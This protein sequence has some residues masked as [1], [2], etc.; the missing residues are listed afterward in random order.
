[1]SKDNMKKSVEARYYRGMAKYMLV[2]G[3]IFSAIAALL[4][5]PSEGDIR[6]L[7]VYLGLVGF[8]FLVL[9]PFIVHYLISYFVLFRHLELYEVIP[10][11]F[12]E[13]SYGGRFGTVF[14]AQFKLHDRL[15][16]MDTHRIFE[17]TFPPFS[18]IPEIGDYANRDVKVAYSPDCDA[19]IVLG[20]M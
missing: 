17:T 13:G 11:H 8:I 15:M 3:L 16:K 12:V 18:F 6:F 20:L 1:M 9:L 19:V 2:I 7:Y 10:A 4:F 5:I 14:T